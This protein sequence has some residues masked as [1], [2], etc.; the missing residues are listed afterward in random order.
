MRIIIEQ[1]SNMAQDPNKLPEEEVTPQEQTTTSDLPTYIQPFIPQMQSFATQLEQAQQTEEEALEERRQA[2]QRVRDAI[3]NRQSVIG[4]IVEAR[5]PVYDEDKEKRARAAVTIQ[6][7]GDVLAA[8]TKGAIAYGKRGAGVVP[9]GTP[10]NAMEGVAKINEMQQKYLERKKAW[11]DLSFNWSMQQAQDAVDAEQAL[12]TLADDRYKAAREDRRVAAKQLQDWY[13][14]MTKTISDTE[15]R[16]TEADEELEREKKMWEW[17]Y[18]NGYVTRGGGYRGGGNGAPKKDYTDQD[19]AT[20]YLRYNEQYDDNGNVRGYKD[21]TSSEQKSLTS[22]AKKHPQTMIHYTLL[23]QG[24]SPML[25]EDIMEDIDETR[26]K[27]I[28]EGY[29]SNSNG[30][31]SLYDYIMQ[32]LSY[33][34]TSDTLGLGESYQPFFL[35]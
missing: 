2:A 10:S 16:R 34:T 7:L 24:Y 13:G 27:E 31:D 21:Y 25:V 6:A 3:T 12:Q 29:A 28:I 17:R 5:K 8:A 14:D 18:R 4:N 20:I 1:E 15:R 22:N 19:L 33:E 30:V 11:D 23:Q 26:A 9:V 35:K 32:Y